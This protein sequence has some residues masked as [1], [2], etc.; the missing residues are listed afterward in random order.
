MSECTAYALSDI[1]RGR[2]QVNSGRPDASRAF[3]PDYFVLPHP[4]WRTTAW[5]RANPWF[6]TELLPELRRR[7]RWALG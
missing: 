3:L 2:A 1:E 4:S 5:E 7:V 6:A